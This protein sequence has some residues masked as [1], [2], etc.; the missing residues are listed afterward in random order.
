MKMLKLLTAIA[1]LCISS[2]GFSQNYLGI[3]PSNYAGVMGTDLQPAS[4]VDGRFVVD[5]N[6]ASVSFNFYT[7]AGSFDTRDM[8]KW[9]TKSFAPDQVST[10]DIYINGGSNEHN[11]WAIAPGDSSQNL[12]PYVIRNYSNTSTK[13]IGIYN[14]VQVDVLNFMFHINPKIAVGAAVK[15]RSITNIDDVDPKL[16][17]L[18][19]QELNYSDLW[20]QQFNEE[21]LNMNH[22]SW[23]EYGLIYSHRY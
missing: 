9:W 20:N 4:F 18:A 17:F 19:E 7:N 5:I 2:T 1:V 6:L 23:M 22:M 14:N 16:A 21:L 12:E 10:G 3:T 15:F 13:P 8:P 11:D